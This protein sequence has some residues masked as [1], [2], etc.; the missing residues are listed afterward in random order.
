MSRTTVINLGAALIVMHS[1]ELLP[2]TDYVDDLPL[3]GPDTT[4][5]VRERDGKSATYVSKLH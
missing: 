1:V 4:T 3:P 2:L 5:P